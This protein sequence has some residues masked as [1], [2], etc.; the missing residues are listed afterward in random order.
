MT[1]ALDMIETVRRWAMVLVGAL[2]FAVAVLIPRILWGQDAPPEELQEAG[3]LAWL[4][5]I[6]WAVGGVVAL[7]GGFGLWKWLKEKL[8]IWFDAL[9]AKTGITF[10]AH[11]DEILVGVAGMAYDRILHSKDGSAWLQKATADG[12]VDP[13]E[14]AELWELTKELGLELVDLNR[15]RSFVASPEAYVESRIGHAIAESNRRG[16]GSNRPGAPAPAPAAP[17]A[18][19]P[20]IP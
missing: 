13:E 20:S 8:G 10:L 5:W 4:Q 16:Q 19:D 6:P 14:W 1:G 9:E 11:V 18:A 15:L 7:A 12:K 3:R 2:I 17:A